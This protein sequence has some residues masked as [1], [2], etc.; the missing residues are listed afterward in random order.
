MTTQPSSQ[1]DLRTSVRYPTRFPV[2]VVRNL[3]RFPAAVKDLS[4]GGA[5][6]EIKTELQVGFFISLA[7][8]E[9]K[10]DATVV[11]AIGNSYG[12]QFSASIDP[13][14]VI[15]HNLAGLEHLRVARVR[16]PESVTAR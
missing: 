5:L 2:E 14:E 4:S 1:R 12:V 13:L 7:A 10:V 16:K 11:R 8:S 9:L 15:R 3:R 6:L